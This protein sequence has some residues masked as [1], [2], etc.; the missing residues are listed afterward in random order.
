MKKDI[1]NSHL[2]SINK[3]INKIPRQKMTI[4]MY[5]NIIQNKKRDILSKSHQYNNQYKLN[6]TIQDTL[7]N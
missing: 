2:I 5:F 6:M 1:L 4:K 3:I 7:K